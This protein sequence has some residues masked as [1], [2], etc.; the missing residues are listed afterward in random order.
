MS[1][2]KPP[3]AGE[4]ETGTTGL[5]AP[6]SCGHGDYGV[7]SAQSRLLPSGRPP[8]AA[9][10]QWLS[11]LTGTTTALPDPFQGSVPPFFPTVCQTQQGCRREKTEG[12]SRAM[13]L[14]A[15]GTTVTGEA[16]SRAGPRDKALSRSQKQSPV[17]ASG[18]WKARPARHL[19]GSAFSWGSA[20]G[21]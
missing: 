18:A 14:S 9:L 19:K 10:Q 7:P 16:R 20:L 11:P 6:H 1:A 4:G 13:A 8:A 15:P 17:S 21:L 2:R 12:H 5:C 3:E